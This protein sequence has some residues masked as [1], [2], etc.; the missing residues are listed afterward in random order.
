MT[1]T[2]IAGFARTPFGRFGG[3]LKEFSAVEL[4]ALV[5]R[6]ALERARV[7]PEDVSETYFG[8]AV[9]A[10]STLVAARQINIKAGLPAST[11]SLTVDR[12]CC[13]SMTAVGL[14]SLRIRAGES[15]VAIA[16]GVESCSRTPYLQ[17]GMRW[18]R[19]PG[20]FT[21]EDPLQF[22]NPLT[23]ESLARIAGEVALKWGVDR[24]G[25][26]DWAHG[27]HEKFFQALERGFFKAEVTAVSRKEGDAVT[28]DESP[29]KGMLRAKLAEL[30]T[31][32]G[33]PTVTPGNAPGLND[34]AS[35]L[36]LMSAEEAQRRG[37][38]PLAEVVRHAQ[39]AGPLDS[40][41]YLP[42][43]AI[44]KVLQAAGVLLSDVKRIEINEAFAVMPLVST[45]LLADGSDVT[46][47]RLRSITNVNGGAVALGHPTGASGARLVMTLANE[48]RARGGGWGVAAICGGFG[49]ADAVLIKV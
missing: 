47:E 8:S 6:E 5:A 2:V 23:G 28:Q 44:R 25:Q 41:P 22:R 19:R 27:S 18:G 7:A 45:K 30:Q 43:E 39:I 13:S 49:Q 24:E 38:E 29:R 20:D 14:A 16:G 17:H 4:G 21:V 9:L 31:V 35:A 1:R 10:G 42:G 48:L 26:D 32:Y 40:S 33:S 36:V 15:A 37:V 3:A 34:G 46:L 12:A 11:P